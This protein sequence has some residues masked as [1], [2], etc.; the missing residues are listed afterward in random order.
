MRGLRLLFVL[1]LGLGLD[2]A[3]IPDTATL[4]MK[5]LDAWSPGN[6]SASSSNSTSNATTGS[7]STT[8]SSEMAHGSSNSTQSSQ[9]LAKP[10][11]SSDVTL[12]KVTIPG[13]SEDSCL[14]EDL[15]AAT[16]G[17]ISHLNGGALIFGDVL[18]MSIL[19][20]SLFIALAGEF[21]VS[22]AVWILGFV[23]GFQLAQMMLAQY[24][25][26]AANAAYG[27]PYEPCTFPLVASLS[28]G[29]IVALLA[30]YFTKFLVFFLGA[31]VGTVAAYELKAFILLVHPGAVES[32]SFCPFWAIALAIGIVAGLIARWRQTDI[33]LI[34][35]ASLGGFGAAFSS[36]AVLALHGLRV[37]EWANQVTFGGVMLVGL[38]TQCCI[39]RKKPRGEFG[40]KKASKE[41]AQPDAK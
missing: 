11:N 18:Y 28:L 30:M 25:V 35:T 32:I 15:D 22:P 1:G 8:T 40:G 37:V 14:A 3:T 29:F 34:A 9:V 5:P 26:F 12:P 20:A 13:V 21:F 6:G 41:E 10:V 17:V 36:R 7:S 16:M 24:E 39:C 4:A 33:F 2:A 23:S 31:A 38:V 19:L 27:L